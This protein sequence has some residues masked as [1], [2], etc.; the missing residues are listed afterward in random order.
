MNTP[1][2]KD[3]DK[4]KKLHNYILALDAEILCI[5]KLASEVA[6]DNCTIK[7][8]I[9]VQNQTKTQNQKKE[10]FGE[11]NSLIPPGHYKFIAFMNAMRDNPHAIPKQIDS[12]AIH[13]DE[14]KFKFYDSQC[15]QMLA[16][17]LKL[18][19]DERGKVLDKIKALG[20]EI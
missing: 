6:S 17:L 18:K 14:Y 10:I 15:L 20:F 16:H 12:H 5:E 4:A 7:F 19:Y 9:R 1:N 2:I 3:L 8:A 13:T 11:D